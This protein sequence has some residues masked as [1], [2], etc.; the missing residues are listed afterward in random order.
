[1][2]TMRTACRRK[3][4]MNETIRVFTT[5]YANHKFLHEDESLTFAEDSL[6]PDGNEAANFTVYPQAEYQTVKGF[7]GAMTE[8]AAYNFANLDEKLQEEFLDKYFDAEKGI[9]YSTCRLTINSSD[10][11][12]DIY[13][14]DDTP[15]DFELK[16]FDMSREEKWVFPAVQRVLAKNPNVEFFAS[17]WSPPAWMKTIGRMDKGGMLKK[18]CRQVWADFFV[19]YLQRLKEEKI[20]VF[21]VTIQN[22]PHA[23]QGWESCFYTAEEE[24]DFAVNYLRPAMDKAGFTDTMIFFWDHNKERVVSRGIT[25]LSDEAGNK[26]LGGIAIHWYSGDHFEALSVFHKL[27]PNKMILGSE[28]STGAHNKCAYA[29][30]EHY[31]HD[32]IGDL[33]NFANGWVDWNMLLDETG[34]PYHW[35]DEQVEFGKKFRAGE[36]TDETITDIEKRFLRPT[37]EHGP[38]MG[39][40][41]ITVDENGKLLFHS[42]YYYMGQI[43]RFIRPG[44]V[45]LGSSLYTNKLEGTAFKN[46]D[47]SIAMVLL[48]TLDRDMPVVIRCNNSIAKTE[49]KQH[50]IMTFVF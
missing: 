6:G 38:W 3:D 8:A 17:P 39:E 2:E 43:S 34:R 27:F 42:S 36:I 35:G 44:A 28:A 50:S 40:S 46:P 25:C 4:T 23:E 15:D 10:F 13:S 19:K 48:N 49:I 18:E 41:P 37:V 24:R 45:R 11:A 33:N 7:G 21:A 9:G 22:E 12:K 26:A 30:G 14:Y 32:I 29:S 1:M 47:G 31:A 16:D 5:D 20:P